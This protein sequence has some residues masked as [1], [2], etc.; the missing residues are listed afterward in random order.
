MSKVAGCK[1]KTKTRTITEKY[2]ILKEV[3]KGESS[4]SIS[5]KYGVSKQTLSG[6][7]KEKTN[8]YSEVEKKQLPRKESGYKSPQMKI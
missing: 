5:K 3:E 4:A 7:L 1:T 6:W 2:K 8:I